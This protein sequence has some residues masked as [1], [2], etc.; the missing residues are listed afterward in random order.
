MSHNTF[1][2]DPI[3]KNNKKRLI[4]HGITDVGHRQQDSTNNIQKHVCSA[5]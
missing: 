2:S 5:L 4:N 1:I 3:V